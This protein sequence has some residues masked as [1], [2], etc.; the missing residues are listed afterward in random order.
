MSDDV[1][2]SATTYKPLDETGFSS[3]PVG[4]KQSDKQPERNR[5]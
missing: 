5:F 2:D 1:G 4:G 3:S